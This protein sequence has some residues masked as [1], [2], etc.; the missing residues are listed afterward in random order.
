MRIISGSLRGRKLAALQGRDVR[1]TADRVKESIF[2]IIGTQTDGARVLDLFAGTGA[3]GIEALSRN[4][5]TA[6]FVDS[7]AASLKVV[8]KNLAL[9]RLTP[10]TRVIKWNIAKNLKPLLAEPARFDLIF[11]DPPYNR[12]LILPTLGHIASHNL[13]APDA[14]IVVEHDPLETIAQD[15]EPWRVT[16]SRRYGQTQVTFLT[17]VMG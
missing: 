15:L 10:V 16:D 3:L 14:V 11:L 7:A 6:V 4:A 13:A 2:N 1:P 17:L 9:C 5:E 8:Q 12:G